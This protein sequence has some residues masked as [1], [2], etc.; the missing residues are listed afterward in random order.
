MTKFG[1]KY[2][3]HPT[4]K[5]ALILQELFEYGFG[6]IATGTILVPDEWVW[7][8][9]VIAISGIIVGAWNKVK[10]YFAETNNFPIDEN[11]PK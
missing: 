11:S 2:K 1:K 3:N 9:Y 7:W 4:P 6:A 8:K 5:W 10:H